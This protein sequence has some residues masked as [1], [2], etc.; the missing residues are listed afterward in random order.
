ML[1]NKF[2][3]STLDEAIDILYRELDDDFKKKFLNLGHSAYHHGFGTTIRNEWGLWEE[4]S[5]LYKFFK[6]TFD[7][8]HADDMSGLILEGLYSKLQGEPYDP[9]PTA[10]HFKEHWEKFGEDLQD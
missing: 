5:V 7:L 6:K 1:L 9:K 8:E 10:E 4:K 2:N 3:P